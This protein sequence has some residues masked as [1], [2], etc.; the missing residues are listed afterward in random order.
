MESRRKE[1]RKRNTV[2]LSHRINDRML[3]IT[4]KKEIL[5]N[6]SAAGG[7]CWV[8]CWTKTIESSTIQVCRADFVHLLKLTLSSVQFF[9]VLHKQIN[10]NFVNQLQRDKLFR[11]VKRALIALFQPPSLCI[12]VAASAAL[13]KSVLWSRLRCLCVAWRPRGLASDGGAKPQR[14][15]RLAHVLLMKI[16]SAKAHPANDKWEK[17]DDDQ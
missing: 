12:L 7:S 4:V 6:H 17:K 8:V 15:G 2:W 11:D 3:N 14:A 5:T 1:A 13:P 16:M 10:D 9:A